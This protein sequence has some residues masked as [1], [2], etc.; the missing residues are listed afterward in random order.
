MCQTEKNVNLE[1]E[2]RQDVARLLHTQ[3]NHLNS[4]QNALYTHT[5]ARKKQKHAPI[6]HYSKIRNTRLYA[7]KIS[8][9]QFH[10]K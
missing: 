4:L 7:E 3:N 9:A 1:F 10:N 6:L 5:R 8:Y 2:I